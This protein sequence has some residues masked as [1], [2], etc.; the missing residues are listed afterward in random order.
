MVAPHAK[1][2]DSES[3]A[4][5]CVKSPSATAA[6][7]SQN[8]VLM[9]GT[10]MSEH[11]IT[12]SLQPVQMEAESGC[13]RCDRRIPLLAFAFLGPNFEAVCNYCAAKQIDDLAAVTIHLGIESAIKQ[14]IE[15]SD[16]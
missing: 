15:D 10:T 13:S 8:S 14:Q 5:I 3:T 16:A 12:D 11:R 1:E 7:P 2:L 9:G 6:A 4:S